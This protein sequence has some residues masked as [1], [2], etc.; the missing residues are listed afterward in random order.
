MRYARE[1]VEQSRA[2]ERR[3]RHRRYAPTRFAVSTQRLPFA[4]RAFQR[5]MEQLSWNSYDIAIRECPTYTI[6]SDVAAGK[7]DVGVVALHDQYI[8]ALE[9]TFEINHVTFTELERLPTYAFL[10]RSH[11]LAK[12]DKVSMAELLQ[13]PF[14]TYDQ[15]ADR[16]EYTEEVVF[17]QI[18]EKTV[19]VS[20]RC[21]KVALVRFT[22]AFSIGPDLTNSNADA[23]H[24]GM[25]EIVAMPVEEISDSLHVGY[26]LQKNVAVSA[27]MAV[28]L[29]YL[30][31]DIIVLK[32]TL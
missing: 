30:R 14:V 11:P 31:D 32:K 15:E 23:F 25:G 22:D 5:F 19:H 2:L 24:S 28:F 16:S 21:S 27:A 29:D 12:R 20:D 13:Y 26:L 3:Y 18:A 9:K 10:R 8:P 4:V 6:I 1:I 17:H 7:S